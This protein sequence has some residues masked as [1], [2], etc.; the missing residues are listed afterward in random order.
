MIPKML[1]EEE[2]GIIPLLTK[3]RCS[4]TRAQNHCP[5][6]AEFSGP[7]LPGLRVWASSIFASIPLL[8]AYIRARLWGDFN[9]LNFKA[10]YSF[11]GQPSNTTS[12]NIFALMFQW[13]VLSSCS[14]NTAPVFLVFGVFFLFHSFPRSSFSRGRDTVSLQTCGS[15]WAECLWVIPSSVK[16]GHSTY[17]GAVVQD[18]WQM[19]K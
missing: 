1:L 6:N 5:E 10:L 17:H 7:R 2:I 18:K 19:T 15:R 8:R 13:I 12:A 4:P 11:L 9:L 16:C 3:L 14:F